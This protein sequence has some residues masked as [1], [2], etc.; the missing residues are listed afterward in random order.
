MKNMHAHFLLTLSCIRCRKRQYLYTLQKTIVLLYAADNNR[1]CILFRN[2]QRLYTLQKKT[3]HLYTSEKD[4][5]CIRCRKRQR[6]YALHKTIVSL[7]AAAPQY[8]FLYCFLQ[9]IKTLSFSA[10]H[11]CT[12]F[13]FCVYV[14]SFFSEAYANAIVFCG[15]YRR[16]RFLR[17]IQTLSFS[18]VYKCVILFCNVY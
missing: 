12:I 13:V 9:R 10:A 4:S 11:T 16:Y 15:V 1:N 6:L 3:A 5:V 2:K 14:C 8:R 17:R 7:Y 18:A